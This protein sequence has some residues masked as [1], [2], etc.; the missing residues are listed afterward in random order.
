MII[1]EM[2]RRVYM[3][4]KMQTCADTRNI[5]MCAFV[6]GFELF[7]RESRVAGPGGE[8]RRNGQRNIVDGHGITPFG[9]VALSVV[10]ACFS[11]YRA[12][13]ACR[14]SRH[15]AQREKARASALPSITVAGTR[16]ALS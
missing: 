4:T 11:C 16:F 7:K 1:E 2:V 10:E 14:R 13:S 12:S 15:S 3:R 6:H 5:G 9:S 8:R